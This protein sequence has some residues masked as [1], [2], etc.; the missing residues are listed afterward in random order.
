METFDEYKA[1]ILKLVEGKDPVAVQRTTVG[2]L[3]RLVSGV[4]SERLSTRPSAD[5]WSVA[6]VL[7]HLSEA[8]ITAFWRYRQIIE[9][10]GC[11]L[12]PYAQDLWAE[13]GHYGSRDPRQSLALFRMLRET[14]LRMFDDLTEEQ[15]QRKGVHAERGPMTVRDLA[16]QIAG[17]DVNHLTQVKSILGE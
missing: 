5:R 12:S 2:E 16:R 6:E 10:E 11:T 9:H 8:E 1:R 7:A 15:W 17:H 3:D 14:N 4:P 13:L